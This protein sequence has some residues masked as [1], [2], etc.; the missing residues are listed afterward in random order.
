MSTRAGAGWALAALL[1]I[2]ALGIGATAYAAGPDLAEAKMDYQMFCVKCHGKTGQGNG[3]AAATLHIKPRNYTDCAKMDKI[4]DATLFKA[5]KFGGKSVGLS[6]EMPAWGK[7]FD[8]NEIKSL[9]AF[10]RSFCKH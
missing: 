10:V 2:A 7:G 9:I 8:D 4:T 6:S 5:I 1:C 3:P